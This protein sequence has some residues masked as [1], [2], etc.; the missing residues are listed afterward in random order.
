MK[1]INKRDFVKLAGMMA[2]GAAVNSTLI[3]RAVAMAKENTGYSVAEVLEIHERLT[4]LDGV[5]PLLGWGIDTTGAIS[6]SSGKGFDLY[7]RGGVTA[8]ASTVSSGRANLPKVRQ[9]IAHHDAIVE[10]RNLVKILTV[11]DLERARREKVFGT[12]YHMQSADCVEDNLDDLEELKLAGVGQ[13]QPTYNYQNR[14]AN[15]SLER[16]KGGLSKAGVD[17][18]KKCNELKIIVDGSHQGVK[19]VFDMIEVSD[20]PVIISH[21]NSAVIHPNSRNIPDDLVKAVAANG[22]FVGLNGWP[23]FVS[24]SQRPTFDDFFAHIDH[25]MDLVGPD[26]VGIGMDYVQLMQGVVPD[27]EVQAIYDQLIGSGIWTVDEYGKPP[28]VY[29][30]GIETPATLHNL[31]GGLLTRGYSE[32]DIAKIWGGNW[33]RVM[34]EVWG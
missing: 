20:S 26:H 11:A 12:W 28:Y 8:A 2:T 16:A 27:I 31:T 32:A 14:F 23:P 13:L 25:M 5:A 9:F 34:T 15:G 4:V 17:L 1:T 21:A 33:T 7:I 3:S 18:I 29:P 30:E 24:S 19:D 6:D 10:S 22:G